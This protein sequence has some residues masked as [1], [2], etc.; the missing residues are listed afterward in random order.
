MLKKLKRHVDEVTGAKAPGSGGALPTRPNRRLD[1]AQ[2][3]QPLTQAEGQL[4][5]LRAL[6]H[7][8]YDAIAPVAA[9]AAAASTEGATADGAPLPDWAALS[10]AVAQLARKHLGEAAAT[11]TDA[12]W[13]A[14][15]Q[16]MAVWAQRLA[17][18]Y[19]RCQAPD[20]VFDINAVRW[21]LLARVPE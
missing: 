11:G 9:K 21:R 19:E 7:V 13:Q 18:L 5:A 20:A 2:F 15:V 17:Q 12:P 6:L 14:A 3:L 10:A 16:S 1:A 8:A 4:D